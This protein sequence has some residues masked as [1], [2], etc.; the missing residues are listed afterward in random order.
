MSAY[1]V[2]EVEITDP[3]GIA[4]YQR[5]V[6]A[7]V[8]KFGGRYLVS[9]GKIVPKEGGWTPSRL[10]IVEF[11]SLEAVESFYEAEEYRELKDLRIRSSNSRF[12]LADGV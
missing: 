9:G 6:L 11:P 8:E 2:A 7:V 4:A 3:E 12:I 5:D 1:I 10:V